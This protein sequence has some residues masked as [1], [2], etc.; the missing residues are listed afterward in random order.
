MPSRDGT[1]L[2][3][4]MGSDA[5]Q[6]TVNGELHRMADNISFGHGI[7]AGIHWPAIPTRRSGWVRR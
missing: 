4:Y 7:H 5:G 2:N 1:T 6:I 3:N